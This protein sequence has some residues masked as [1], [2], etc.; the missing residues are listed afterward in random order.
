MVE[1][2]SGF[3]I[4][5]I[6]ICFVGG[7]ALAGLFFVGRIIWNAWSKSLKFF[8]KYTIFRRKYPESSVKW[9]TECVNKG[10]SYHD[11]KKVLMINDVPM[12]TIN[13]SLWILKKV[14]IKLNLTGGGTNV[15][16]IGQDNSQNQS[17]RELPTG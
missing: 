12:A 7:F 10:M 13:E 9:V 11:A 15:G 2:F 1:W 6:E 8:F 17:K 5:I 14:M 4:P 3:L 16:G